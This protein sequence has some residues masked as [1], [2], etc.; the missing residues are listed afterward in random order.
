MSVDLDKIEGRIDRAMA[1]G[2]EVS[3]SLGGVQIK[4]LGQLLE[5]AKMMSISGVAVPYHLRGNPGSCLAVAMRA[6]RSGFDPFMLAE[7]SYTMA[8]NQ[9]TDDGRWEKVETLA[10]DSFVIRAIIEAHAN[11]TGPLRYSFDGEGDDL[12]CTVTAFPKGEKE[13]LTHKSEPLGRMKAARGR[14]DKGDIKGSPLWDT[15]PRQQLGYA[16]GRDFC[17]RYFPQ[18]LM[19]YYDRDEMDENV[20]PVREIE[21]VKTSG[22]RERLSKPKGEQRGFDHAAITKTIDGEVAK[23]DA[24]PPEPVKETAF[25]IQ[26]REEAQAASD[27]LPGPPGDVGTGAADL[28]PGSTPGDAPASQQVT[29][30]TEST[31]SDSVAQAEPDASAGVAFKPVAPPVDGPDYV[32]YVG[33][34]LKGP[35]MDVEGFVREW[36]KSTFERGLRNTLP[37]YDKNHTTEAMALVTEHIKGLKAEA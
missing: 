19:G 7:H 26:A 8:K 3:M 16:T 35:M 34:K 21:P 27:Q 29:A 32:R 1:A 31:H 6:L 2:T 17:R 36:W 15:N 12:T 11:L 25:P 5:I 18:V 33:E 28:S 24:P 20:V 13:P 4:D 9:K 14:N 30:A 22:L 23:R 37:N 10:F